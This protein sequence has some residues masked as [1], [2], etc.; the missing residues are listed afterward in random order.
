MTLIEVAVVIFGVFA[1]YWVVSK[2]FFRPPPAKDAQ[3]SAAAP[4][5]ARAEHWLRRPSGQF[6]SPKTATALLV[7]TKTF[8]SATV[9]V[10]N[11][12]P[13]PK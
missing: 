1:G 6:S 3:A 8:P 5:E 13:V 12:F 10:M 2:L 11:L 7:P 4:L 9:G